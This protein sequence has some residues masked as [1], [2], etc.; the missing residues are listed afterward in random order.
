MAVNVISLYRWLGIDCTKWPWK[1]PLFTTR[2]LRR[3]TA[4]V[5][6]TKA[7][8]EVFLLASTTKAYLKMFQDCIQVSDLWKSCVLF[9]CMFFEV[10]KPCRTARLSGIFFSPV[11]FFFLSLRSDTARGRSRTAFLQRPLSTDRARR[12][13]WVCPRIPA[14]VAAGFHKWRVCLLFTI[15]L[16]L[17]TPSKPLTLLDLMEILDLLFPKGLLSSKRVL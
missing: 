13:G 10:R 17:K 16:N 8:S 1:L 5:T 12:P 11:V 9:V 15:W 7:D 14:G 2:R 3:S 4:T 6:S